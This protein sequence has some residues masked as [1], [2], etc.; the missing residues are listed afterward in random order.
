MIC[1]MPKVQALQVDMLTLLVRDPASDG[2]VPRLAQQFT[3]RK[4]CSYT[5]S[6]VLGEHLPLHNLP[7]PA[8]SP[9]CPVHGQITL[10]ERTTVAADVVPLYWRVV[11]RI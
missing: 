2:S 1:S 4:T 8:I 7:M 3:K 9:R 11:E 5:R 6:E 10:L